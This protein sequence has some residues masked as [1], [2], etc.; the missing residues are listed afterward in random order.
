MTERHQE[1]SEL[2]QP[3][4]L[5]ADIGS[6]YPFG[7]PRFHVEALSFTVRGP[8]YVATDA[9]TAAQARRDVLAHYDDLLSTLDCHGWVLMNAPRF[10]FRSSLERALWTV[11]GEVAKAPREIM[12]YAEIELEICKAEG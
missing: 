4:M 6:L 7:L 10:E 9:R 1:L 11:A 3:Y 2:L 5:S 8:L 12:V